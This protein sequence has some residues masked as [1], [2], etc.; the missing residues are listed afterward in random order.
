LGGVIRGDISVA[1]STYNTLAVNS[2]A[3]VVD[4][5]VGVVTFSLKLVLLSVVEGQVH[6]ATIAAAIL[7]G[8]VHKLLFGEG[9]KLL[10]LNPVGTF[11][12]TC[13][14]ESPA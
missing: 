5:L 6:G 8:A 11:K 2:M 4:S 14:G 10:S 13:A 3:L 12:S 9:D 7:G 1:G